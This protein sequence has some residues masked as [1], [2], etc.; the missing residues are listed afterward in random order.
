MASKKHRKRIW[1]KHNPVQ[2]I[3]FFINQECVPTSKD[4]PLFDLKGDIKT[5]TLTEI[6][7]CGVAFSKTITIKGNKDNNKLF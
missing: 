6:P 2:K 3:R 4:L 1:R 7:M 5:I